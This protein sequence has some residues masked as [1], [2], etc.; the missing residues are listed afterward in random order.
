MGAGASLPYADEASALA[1]GKTQDEVDTWR[2]EHPDAAMSEEKIDDTSK[3]T[4]AETADSGTVAQNTEKIDDSTSTEIADSG[5]MTQN[6]EKTGDDSTSTE[7]QNKEKFDDSMSTEFAGSS[8]TASSTT[9]IGYPIANDSGT[10][11]KMEGSFSQQTCVNMWSELND[12]ND[13][14]VTNFNE[15]AELMVRNME[16]Y[17]TTGEVVSGELPFAVQFCSPGWL[18][19]VENDRL[20]TLREHFCQ[21]TRDATLKAIKDDEGRKQLME[22]VGN[23]IS[24]RTTTGCNLISKGDKMRWLASTVSTMKRNNG[25]ACAKRGSTLEA[26][27]HHFVVVVYGRADW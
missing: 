25:R 11:T 19:W 22:T 16:E 13:G 27:R 8:G 17:V 4:S 14:K 3:L 1:A 21:M 7:T 26:R 12:A 23:L 2:S 5:T 10:A 15:L 24:S 18:P 20:V 9:T 6:K